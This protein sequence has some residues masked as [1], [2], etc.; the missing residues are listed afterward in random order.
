MSSKGNNYN[1]SKS[2]AVANLSGYIII[3]LI[4]AGYMLRDLSFDR[5][6]GQAVTVADG[7]AR[8]MLEVGLGYQTQNGTQNTHG[9]SKIRNI[10]AVNSDGLL[11]QDVFALSGQV[12][13]DPWGLPYLYRFVQ[14]DGKNLL[15]VWSLGPN[16]KDDSGGESHDLNEGFLEDDAGSYLVIARP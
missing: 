6:K 3:C 12:G 2:I 4:S 7:L 5:K 11:E 16:G 1:S 8:Q 14:K 13:K 10:A 15:Y 9:G